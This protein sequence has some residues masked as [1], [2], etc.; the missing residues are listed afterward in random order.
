MQEESESEEHYSP[1]VKK[2]ICCCTCVWP[3]TH[4]T[5]KSYKEIL[6]EGLKNKHSVFW[7]MILQIIIEPYMEWA[8]AAR[9]NMQNPVYTNAG[10]RFSNGIGIISALV[11]FILVPA[12]LFRLYEEPI[13][14]VSQNGFTEKWGVI[15]YDIRKRVNYHVNYIAILTIRR[16]LFLSIV[17]DLGHLQSIQM[18]L[19][20]FCNLAMHIYIGTK[21]MVTK[22]MNWLHFLEELV[23]AACCTHMVIFMMSGDELTS[24]AWG[25]SMIIIMNLHFLIVSMYMMYLTK[26]MLRVLF[27]RHYAPW[28]VW[29]VRKYGFR[30]GGKLHNMF[31]IDVGSRRVKQMMELDINQ[32][33]RNITSGVVNLHPTE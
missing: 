9:L 25:W 30:I 12:I 29:A 20:G 24:I 11:A 17:F 13:G 8:I 31:T 28:K 1:D 23:I 4:L 16:L 22:H 14:N 21:P 10:D 2:V 26:E 33:T 7:T 18:L 5:N 32:G 15:F 27:R 19:M 6:F 3:R